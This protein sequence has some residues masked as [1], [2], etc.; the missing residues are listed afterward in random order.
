[1]G[2]G[3]FGGLDADPAV[4]GLDAVRADH[5]GPQI[6]LGDLRQVLH[7][8]GDPQQHVPQC[9]QVGWPA[10]TAP[11]QPPDGRYRADQVVGIGVGQRGQPGGAGSQRIVGGT[12]GPSSTSGP[13]TRSCSTLII[14][15]TPPVTTG[16]TMTPASR[17]PKASASTPNPRRTSSGPCSPV[18]TSRAS[19]VCSR[20]GTSARSVTGPANRAAAA[21]AACSVVTSMLSASRTP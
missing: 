18:S 2:V 5:N 9:G 10:V 3:G 13:T 19:P 17:L 16:W 14:T 1:M 20:P 7:H 8:P 15:S 21:I 4:N 11:Q 12:A 6:E